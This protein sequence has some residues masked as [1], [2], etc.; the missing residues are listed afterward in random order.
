MKPS[1]AADSAYKVLGSD[2]LNLFAPNADGTATFSL[3][4]L[5]DLVQVNGTYQVRTG[6]SYVGDQGDNVVNGSDGKDSLSGG[7]GNDTL[8]GA[9]VMT[10]CTAV[11]EMTGCLVTRA[12]T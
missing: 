10:N 1:G 7:A 9:P 4:E 12:R 6:Q 11:K 2:G 8:H 5:Q 3:G